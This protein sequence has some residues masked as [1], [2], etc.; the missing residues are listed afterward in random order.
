MWGLGLEKGSELGSDHSRAK[1]SKGTARAQELG[2]PL[3]LSS[4]SIIAP[5]RP[6]GHNLKAR[7]N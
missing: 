5:R 2:F 6:A 4:V 7:D 3:D 1:P